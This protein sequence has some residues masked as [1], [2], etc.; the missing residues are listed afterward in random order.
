MLWC[1]QFPSRLVTVFLGTLCSCTK[2]INAPYLFY[3]EHGFAFN[4]MQG[5]RASS[6]GKG[7]VSWIFSSCGGNLAYILELRRGWPF[8]NH[9][10]SA[11]SGHLSIYEGHLKNF[12]EAWQGNRDTSRGEAGDPGSLSSSNMDIEIPINFQEESHIFTFRSIELHVPL[13][14]SKGCEASCRGQ[15]VT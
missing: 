12:F 8:K 4:A 11:M 9:V 7:E 13:E 2:Q 10:C 15:A 6:C 1:R 14:V 5:N 3:E